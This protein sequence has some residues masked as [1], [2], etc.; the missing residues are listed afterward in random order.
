MGIESCAC[1]CWRRVGA[2]ATRR[3]M[4]VNCL[5]GGLLVSWPLSAQQA[6]MRGYPA[7]ALVTRAPLEQAAR[8]TP[9]PKRIRSYIRAMTSAPHLMG[10]PGSKRV[11]EW[12]LARFKEW[13]LDAQIEQYEALIPLPLEQVLEIRGKSPW[14]AQL[15]EEV[16]AEDADSKQSHRTSCTGSMAT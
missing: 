6:P 5:I 15:R 4:R 13:G 14:R 10:T 16:F 12:A 1:R 2:N 7:D 3:R 8:T 11:A 9:D